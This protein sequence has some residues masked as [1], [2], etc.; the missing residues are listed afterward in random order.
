L[1]GKAKLSPRNR[2]WPAKLGCRGSNL[3]RTT[4]QFEIRRRIISH[5]L[6]G[7][8]G[9]YPSSPSRKD[10]PSSTPNAKPARENAGGFVRAS[11]NANP[12]SPRSISHFFRN[13]ASARRKTE[14]LSDGVFSS[15][16]ESLRAHRNSARTRKVRGQSPRNV[17]AFT[18][19]E[20][21]RTLLMAEGLSRTLERCCAV[22][23]MGGWA[24]P[25]KITPSIPS[26]FF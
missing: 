22:V 3:R 2:G 4:I 18:L 26:R 20:V 14:V 6:V 21:T 25:H 19:F 17:I 11:E 5:R 23:P 24:G 1:L 13:R 9:A 12:A 8:D 15:C 16:R 10:P 7:R